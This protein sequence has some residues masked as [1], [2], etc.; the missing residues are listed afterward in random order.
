MA[1][2]RAVKKITGVELDIKWLM[3]FIIMEKKSAAFLQK[4]SQTLRV[5]ILNLPLVGIG[6]NIFEAAAVPDSLKGIAGGY[7]RTGKLRESLTAA[8]W[9]RDCKCPA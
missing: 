6:L 3:T 7:M 8:D 5:E 4:Q 1:V 9:R 2:Y